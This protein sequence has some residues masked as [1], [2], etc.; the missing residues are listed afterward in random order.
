MCVVPNVAGRGSFDSP[1]RSIDDVLAGATPPLRHS[2]HV[3]RSGVVVASMLNHETQQLEVVAAIKA[4]HADLPQRIQRALVP[5]EQVRDGRRVARASSRCCIEG[6]CSSGLRE[7]D[8]LDKVPALAGHVANGARRNAAHAAQDRRRSKSDESSCGSDSGDALSNILTAPM[9]LAS[10]SDQCGRGRAQTSDP[11]NE[12]A[13]R[14]G[15][16]CLHHRRHAGRC[17]RRRRRW[18]AE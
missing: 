6:G 16:T 7:C 1:G 8:S 4:F 3:P 10:D 13:Q 5:L 2:C 9:T 12:A 14:I 15:S 18:P 17:P 11:N